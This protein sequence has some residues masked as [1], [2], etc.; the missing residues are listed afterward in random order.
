VITRLGF[1]IGGKGTVV[2]KKLGTLQWIL[3]G[4][5]VALG[6]AGWRFGWPAAIG[7]GVALAGLGIAAGGVED[8]LNREVSLSYRDEG[9]HYQTY[10]GTSAVLM[11]VTLVLAGLAMLV[12]GLA[13]AAGLGAWLWGNIRAHPGPALVLAGLAMIAY[14]GMEALGAREN[15]LSASFLNFLGSVPARIFGVLLVVVGLVTLGAGT[16]ELIAPQA[17]DALLA[18]L[19][20]ALLPQIP[21]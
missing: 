20:E 8:M 18:Y 3:I 10:S 6:Y 21:K 19:K 9:G 5:G 4:L 7:L 2:A 15:R 11:G 17:F 12:G 14:G 1:L 16:L 13:Y